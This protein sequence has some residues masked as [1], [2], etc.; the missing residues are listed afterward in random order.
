M[1]LAGPSGTDHPPRLWPVICLGVIGHTAFSASR[2]TV[3]LAAISLQA[4]AFVVG[5]LLSLYALL[6][7]LLSVSAG[8]WIDR[9]GTRVPMLLGSA[10]VAVGFVLPAIWLSLPA[11]FLNSLL[12]G[13][14]F[15]FF[16]MAVQKLTGDLGEGAQRMRHFGHLAVGYSVSAF[17]GPVLAGLLID[18]WGAGSSF[19]A[20]F[21]ASTLLIAA[22]FA[23]LR[24]RWTFSGQASRVAPAQARRGR[25]LDLLASRPLRLLFLSVVVTSTVWDVHMFLTP[26]QG[27]R[28]GLSA[29]QI[30]AVLGAFSAATFTVRLSL[31]LI[32]RRLREWQL[33]GVAQL[34]AAAVFLVFPL[35]TS[36]W[37]LMG[38]SFLLGLGLGVG[39]PAVMSLLHEVSPAGRV[40]EAVGLRMSL[41]N[42]TQVV[43][44]T[45]F[46]VVGTLLASVMGGALA[47]A[48]LFWCVSVG[49]VAGG[50]TALR[51]RTQRGDPVDPPA[52]SG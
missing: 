24:W 46:G 49:A 25:L 19:G 26:I 51:Q 27:S 32:S 4:S 11:L 12:V 15:M 52:A 23:L 2:M 40:G 1:S 42:G 21:A 5:L 47:Y 20:S 18:R 17:C 30:G 8:R 13:T 7:M 31:P 22:A 10:V 3:S 36:F 6:P 38:L 34:V 14:G 28:I 16:H 37:G 29:S 44:P 45:L 48:P 9:V 35:V 43:L 39:Q 33:I 41:V 50:L